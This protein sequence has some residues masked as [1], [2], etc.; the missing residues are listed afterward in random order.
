MGRSRGHAIAVARLM[1]PQLSE[2]FGLALAGV[3]RA[4]G[5]S[6]RPPP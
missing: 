4:S 1:A 2:A 6:S 3:S 5:F